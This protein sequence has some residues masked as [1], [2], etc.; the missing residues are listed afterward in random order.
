MKVLHTQHLLNTGGKPPDPQAGRP[1]RGLLCGA[2]PDG[3]VSGA[4]EQGLPA[5]F[6]GPRVKE[7]E[8][9][10]VSTG[11]QGNHLTKFSCSAVELDIARAP[12]FLSSLPKRS[13]I[14][15]LISII[16]GAIIKI[17]ILYSPRAMTLEGWIV[18]K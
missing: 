12:L 6:H 1:L 13:G 18:N 16:P 11:G 14:I 5:Q 2:W 17:D 3:P 10:W 9:R 4:G 15:L 8:E 7:A